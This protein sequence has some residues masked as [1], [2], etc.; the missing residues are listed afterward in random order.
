MPKFGVRVPHNL[1]Q[2]EARSRLERFA[3][4][5]QQKF[6]DKVSDLSQTWEGD[7]LNFRFKTY[8]IQLQGGIAVTDKELDL[9]G[10]LPFAAMMFKGKIES[11]IREQLERIVA[12]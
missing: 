5:L 2:Q 4:V 12:A 3:D 9:N 1:T 11:E 10:D 7:T 6:Q 8:G